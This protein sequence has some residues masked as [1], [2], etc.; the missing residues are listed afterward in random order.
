MFQL[1][2]C[3]SEK[4]GADLLRSEIPLGENANERVSGIELYVAIGKQKHGEPPDATKSADL[5]VPPVAVDCVCNQF[6][7]PSYVS[8]CGGRNSALLNQVDHLS[9]AYGGDAD[10]I[11][12]SDRGIYEGGSR[13]PRPRIR[14]E[15]PEGG[16]GVGDR[17]DHQK[18]ERG[19]F[20]SISARF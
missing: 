11:A 8:Q 6:S 1:G 9:H 13:T 19:K 3:R 7:A 16:V 5:S 20:A 10:A 4:S 15:I 18:S 2:V 14:K 12:V 17:D